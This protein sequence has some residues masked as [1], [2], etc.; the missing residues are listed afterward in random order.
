MVF[1]LGQ[2]FGSTFSADLLRSGDTESVGDLLESLLVLEW[3]DLVFQFLQS[4]FL[5]G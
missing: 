3:L 2:A 4:H 5:P 1:V